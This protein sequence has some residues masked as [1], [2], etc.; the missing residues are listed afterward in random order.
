MPFIAVTATDAREAAPYIASLEKRGASTRLL[1]PDAYTSLDDAMRG[2]G[3]LLLCGG[4]DVHPRH[5]G[6][7]I[8]PN[9]NVETL[10]ERD[11]VEFSM[12]RDAL[13]RD[14]P[15]LAICRGLQ[16]L[17]VAFGGS[18]LQDIPDHG[19]GNI[20]DKD[21]LDE[22]VTHPAYVSP[23]SKLGHVVGLGAVYTV[24]SW[25]HQGLRDAQRAPGLL[26]SSYHPTDGIVEGLE[27]PAHD[28]VI[29][30]QCHPEREWEVPR[31]FLHLFE[32][33]VERAEAFER[34]G[35]RA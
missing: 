22:P 23:G 9:A 25:H 35:A 19:P 3:G 24:N 7:D 31:N 12:L 28:W 1:T 20:E 2:A 11:Q 5:Y 33:F 34:L 8:D 29:G 14:M 26:A 13:S 32:G 21:E 16:L 27:S 18:L 17:N 15:V 10:E 6:Q 30:V 4:V